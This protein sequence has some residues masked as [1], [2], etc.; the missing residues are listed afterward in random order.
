MKNKNL[1]DSF[2]NAINGI[3]HAI[4]YERNMKIHVCIAVILFVMALFFDLS[5]LEFMIISL[6]VCIV[7]VCELINT[8]IEVM[9]DLVTSEYH[10]KAKIVKDVSAGAV[11]ISA[12]FSVVVAYFVF[13]ERVSSGLEIG[14]D[15]IRNYKMHISVIALIITLFVVLA[16]K[17]LSGKG[18]PLK[19]G[20][21]SGHAAIASSITTSIALWSVNIKITILCM[22][23]ALLVIQSR[24]ES[25]THNF[26]EVFWGTILGFLF[27]LLLFQLF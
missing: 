26:M 9:V 25:K 15:R 11:L 21:P 27:T 10:P 20:M 24:L 18:T 4:K 19:G 16:L 2:N 5:K 6:T 13:F 23:L 12:F 14:I 1:I 7:I 22:I 8:A 3:L 17:A